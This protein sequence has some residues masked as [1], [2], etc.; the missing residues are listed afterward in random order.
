[1][2]P[3]IQRAVVVTG[4]MALC[5]SPGR[6]QDLPLP[7]ELASGALAAP[8]SDPSEEFLKAYMQVQ[9]AESI[10]KDGRLRDALALYRGAADLINGIARNSPT[11]QPLIV[12]YRGRRIAEAV[13]RLQ[14]QLGQQADGVLGGVAPSV[15]TGEGAAASAPLRTLSAGGRPLPGAQ[16]AQPPVS[17]ENPGDDELNRRVLALQQKLS[18]SEQ[19][20]ADLEERLNTTSIQ[21]RELAK[22][23]QRS[24]EEEKRLKARL[25][26]LGDSSAGE[27]VRLLKE[28]LAAAETDRDNAIALTKDL[29]TRLVDA[30]RARDEAI[31]QAARYA[32]LE[33]KYTLA[34]EENAGL[35][36]RLEELKDG[37]TALAKKDEEIAA[38]KGD[39]GRL[40]NEIAEAQRLNADYEATVTQLQ[41][42]LDNSSAQLAAYK[43][44]GVAPEEIDRMAREN[45]L[46]RG[47]VAKQLQ[48]QA[49]REQARRVLLEE[50]GRHE[51]A[52]EDYKAQLDL[53]GESLVDLEDD[54]REKLDALLREPVV[55]ISAAGTE[56]SADME[57]SVAA[58]KAE[59]LEAGGDEELT[60]I[61][62]DA[63]GEPSIET[64]GAEAPAEFAELA[65]EARA[66]FDAENFREAERLYE[67]ILAKEPDS[68][69]ALS[70]LGVVYFRTSRF[71]A[72]E[73]ML[74]KAVTIE[75]ADA[76]SHQTLGIVY[77]QQERFDEAMESL[78]RTLDLNP[79]NA[80]AHNY[81][82]IT[83]S[84]KGW[85][86]AAEKEVLEA[87]AL[88]PNYSD[89]HFNLAVI[90]AMN[91]PPSLELA[92]RHYKKALDLGA[93]PDT[94]LERML[95]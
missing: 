63:A 57:V 12:E 23:V 70:N 27:E 73:M 46:L 67:N 87:I 48:S 71:K 88:D 92:R 69:F 6:A 18:Q 80:I 95:Q 17:A 62:E 42:D 60:E 5:L 40:R 29:E 9:K 21:M 31:E 41:A 91:E 61:G 51:V 44:K 14:G 75:P 24:E 86:E 54:E 10:E 11:W 74:K 1:M 33:A 47:I 3:T 65:R 36:A 94:V 93:P 16:V 50:L 43:L 4:M 49:R 22:R 35:A 59:G 45:T 90:Y 39:I 25:A 83:A 64:A 55:R 56:S 32:E 68:V 89:A 79:R 30:E 85:P 78:T 82:G 13:T 37:E 8:V 20:R 84:R 19:A 58:L 38:L 15:A 76:F 26:E 81:L 7:G 34:L 53:L 2:I 66:A 77:Y 52:A 28:Q 72:A